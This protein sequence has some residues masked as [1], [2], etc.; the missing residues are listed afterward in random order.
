MPHGIAFSTDYKRL[1]VSNMMKKMQNGINLMLFGM[2][3]MMMVM[4]SQL[5]L[6]NERRKKE[7]KKRKGGVANMNIHKQKLKFQMDSR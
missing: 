7:K 4:M 3:M 6:K 2:L 5:P 1:Y